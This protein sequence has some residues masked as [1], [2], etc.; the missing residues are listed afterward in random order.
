MNNLLQNMKSGFANVKELFGI[1][2]SDDD[3]IV[4]SYDM[5]INSNDRGLSETAKQL[6]IIEQEQ[7]NNRLDLL[8]LKSKSKKIVQKK[9]LKKNLKS[10]TEIKPTKSNRSS[11]KKRTGD[12]HIK[13]KQPEK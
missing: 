12:D 6:K 3:D 7:E 5:Y 9:E 2:L 1:F 11:Q 8:E 13:D 10:E 4:D